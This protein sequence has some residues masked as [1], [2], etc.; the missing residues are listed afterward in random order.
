[1]AIIRESTLT[2]FQI[3]SLLALA[4]ICTAAVFHEALI[5]REAPFLT[6]G[7]GAPWIG[8]PF[9]PTSDAVPV[10]RNNTPASSFSRTFEIASVPADAILSARGLSS[11]ELSINGATLLWDPPLASWR[12]MIEI[13]VSEKLR[14]GSNEIRARVRNA[15]GPSLLQLALRG[16]G[17][18]IE[19]DETWE[20]VAPGIPPVKASRANDTQLFFDTYIMPSPGQAF[21]EKGF[22]VAALF[23]FFAGLSKV[24][25]SRFAAA[26][27]RFLPLGVLGAVTCYWLAVF[28]FKISQLPVMMGFDIPAHLAY[29]DHLLEFRTLPDPVEGWSSYHP[30]LFYLLT[31]AFVFAGDVARD[32]GAGQVVYRFVSFGSGLT[33]VWCTH[34]FARRYFGEEPI[35]TSLAT[36]FAGLLPMNLYV[37]A[38]VSNESLLAAWLSLAMFFACTALLTARTTVL[39]IFAIGA[40]LGLAITTKFSGLSLVPVIALVVA[41]KIGM[42]EGDDRPAAVRRAALAFTTV[43]LTTALVGGWFYLRNYLQH[44]QWVIWNVNLPGA[45]TWWE[46]PGFHTASYYFGFGESL[47]HPFFAGFYSFWDGIYS[48]FWGDGLLAGMV[49]A[50]TRHPYWNYEYMALGYW[51]ALPL[52]AAI[53][54]G[55][56]MLLRQAFRDRDL[57]VRITASFLVLVIIVL[58]F[59]LLIVTFRVPY[60]AQAKAFYVLGATIPLSLAAA[61]GIASIDDALK[62]GR[63]TYL[64]IPLH[65]VLGMAGAVIVASFLG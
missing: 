47:R 62:S 28:Y 5:A 37:S 58:L 15:T 50:T 52:T 63:A 3:A 10:V 43:I 35:K 54:V 55:I 51:T 16:D 39:H 18:N 45:T 46:Y 38:Y 59:S 53:I 22:V 33:I 8:Y 64:R 61:T 25:R 19:T 14:P 41:G 20:V 65:G 9:T 42:L 30:P 23:L 49:Q 57:Q 60:Y 2:R 12:E 1:M 40:A 24:V 26:N 36:A 27:L 32:S 21:Q 6:R 4:I 56:A 29:F 44:G 13:D 7:N 17:I 31:V 34:F 48:T 11:L